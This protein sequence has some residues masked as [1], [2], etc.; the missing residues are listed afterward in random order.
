MLVYYVICKYISPPT[1]SLVEVA[2]FPPRTEEEE[3]ALAAGAVIEATSDTDSYE[4]KEKGTIDTK[5]A[6]EK[7]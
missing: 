4:K 5:M 3:Q 1:E 6:D 7:V 2:T